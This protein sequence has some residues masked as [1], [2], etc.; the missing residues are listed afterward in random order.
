M[1]HE[2]LPGA[3]KSSFDLVD[4]ELV[5]KE[6][7]LAPGAVFLDLGCGM[8]DYALA[9]AE[10]IGPH[11]LVYAADGWQEGIAILERRARDRNLTNIQTLV[12]RI[13][14]RVPLSD[15]SV[16][17]CLMATVLHDFARDAN[18]Q[19]ALQE[20]ARVLK[21]GGVLGVVE[22]KKV[23][24]PPGPPIQIRLDPS[25]VEA[26][27]RPFGFRPLRTVDAGAYTYCTIARK[28]FPT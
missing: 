3:G 2:K 16:D 11:G 15:Q 27:I 4:H 23:D 20:T 17:I 26:I 28:E 21:K 10:K 1:A 14:G 25:Q 18:E 9:A 6:L 7:G 24:K 12:A 19:E 22:F 8:G 13:P 5:F